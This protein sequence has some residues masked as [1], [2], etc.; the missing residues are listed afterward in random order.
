[1]RLWRGISWL[2]VTNA[3]AERFVRTIKG[4][5]LERMIIFGESAVRK[6]TAEFITHYHSEHN[7]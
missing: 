1:M 3:Y 4:S 6:A 2:Q 5:C 7:H